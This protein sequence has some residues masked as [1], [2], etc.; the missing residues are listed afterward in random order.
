MKFIIGIVVLFLIT[1]VVQ[2]SYADNSCGNTYN[3]R[4]QHAKQE[5]Y[6]NNWCSDHQYKVFTGLKRCWPVS[7]TANHCEYDYY[8]AFPKVCETDKISQQEIDESI[9]C[10]DIAM[11]DV[12][13]IMGNAGRVG[14]DV[15]NQIKWLLDDRTNPL[16]INHDKAQEMLKRMHSGYPL[17]K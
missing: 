1:F 9:Q 4:L 6:F 7:E 3:T 17:Q 11:W 16:K 12:K 2:I 10:K 5:I 8:Y 14:A 15:V 13:A